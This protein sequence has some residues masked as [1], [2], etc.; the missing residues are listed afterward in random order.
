MIKKLREES[1]AN[2]PS[3]IRVATVYF[4]PQNN[5]TNIQ[6]DYFIHKADKWLVF[7]HELE[8]LSLDEIAAGKGK[9]IAEL[10]K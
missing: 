1:R 2:T 5:K 10:L 9:E 3:D 4:K 7:P 8:G 6:P